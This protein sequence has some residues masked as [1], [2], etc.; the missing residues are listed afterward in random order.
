[1]AKEG[2]SALSEKAKLRYLNDTNL[3]TLEVLKALAE[4]YHLLV[5]GG[6]DT[7]IEDDTHTIGNPTFFA[8]EKLL[9]KI[10]FVCR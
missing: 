2:P 5:T 4:K 6:S 3:E 7:H 1:M 10:A 9:E 8:D